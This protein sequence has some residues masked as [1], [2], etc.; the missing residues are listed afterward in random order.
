MSSGY[1]LFLNEQSS[2]FQH[3]QT[4]TEGTSRS[5]LR[6]KV[7]GKTWATDEIGHLVVYFPQL[8]V[9]GCQSLLVPARKTPAT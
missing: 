8:A 3:L 7:L 2:S 9:E 6:E 5:P 4:C 1:P